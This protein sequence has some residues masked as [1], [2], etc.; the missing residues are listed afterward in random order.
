MILLGVWYKASNTYAGIK[1][2]DPSY[3]V[4]DELGEPALK[5]QIGPEGID[6]VAYYWY[7][8][9][10]FEFSFQ[11]PFINR[12][13][14]LSSFFIV[15]CEK[16]VVTKKDNIEDVESYIRKAEKKIRQVERNLNK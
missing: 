1:I 13:H 11:Y 2:G 16:G 15:M 10:G 9:E 4:I 12:T 8:K 3:Q 7:K 5:F 6:I 14:N